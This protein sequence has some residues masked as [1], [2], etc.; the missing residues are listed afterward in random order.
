MQATKASP[1]SRLLW[2]ASTSRL[3]AHVSGAEFLLGFGLFV[4]LIGG[5][6]VAFLIL[7]GP[8]RFFSQTSSG[9]RILTRV[10]LTEDD[11]PSDDPPRCHAM[12]ANQCNESVFEEGTV[13]A[14]SSSR[15]WPACGPPEVSTS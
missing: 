2:F 12:P 3:P 6:R 1:P 13:T 15:D 5:C 10:G 7:C 4:G 8:I 9:S 11:R 14:Y